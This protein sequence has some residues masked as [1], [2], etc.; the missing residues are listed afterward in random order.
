MKKHNQLFLLVVLLLSIASYAQTEKPALLLSLGYFNSNNQ[1][2]YVVVKAKSK[3]DRKFQMIKGIDVAV[4]I[5]AISPENLIGKGITDEKG[6][7]S[8]FIPASAKSEWNKSAKQSFLL[9][10]KPNKQFNEAQ[11]S[12]DISKAKLEIDTSADKKISAK[13]LELKDSVWSVVKGVDVKL[14]VKRLGGDLNVNETPS[15]T[16]D[17]LGMVEA[18][19][20][21]DSLPGDAKGN[22]VLVA[23]V[24][25]NELYGNLS[26][27]KQV[28]WGASYKYVSQFDRRTLFARR[29]KSPVWLELMAY[30]IVVAVW[31]VLIFLVGRIRKI[32]EL[33]AV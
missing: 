13:L 4:Y 6:E 25:D 32:I 30:S 15:Y 2:Q 10:S 19:F 12:L 11:G 5:T 8:L 7:I 33:G 23:K 28:P 3:I 22:L 21:R 29:G 18:E 1:H 31:G 16:T 26:A 24:E 9:V 14:A 20:K 17:S 27:E